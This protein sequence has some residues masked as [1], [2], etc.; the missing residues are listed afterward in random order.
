MAS[1]AF[2]P[3]ASCV[4][5][6]L[7]VTGDA[8]R[9]RFPHPLPRLVAARARDTR[10]SA[11]EQE[12]RQ[13]MAKCLRIQSDNVGLPSLVIG[14]AGPALA[15]P[16]RRVPAVESLSLCDIGSNRLVA[17]DTETR[18]RLLRE[19]FM[20]LRAVFLE[21]GVPLDERPR[22]DELFEDVL[23]VRRAIPS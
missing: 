16:D 23:R 20:A 10:M 8:I 7:L 13:I 17:I 6:I 15:F 3:Q 14:V 18:L 11:L 4:R 21:L 12:I 5:I 9:G 1:G 22:I 19:R 2:G